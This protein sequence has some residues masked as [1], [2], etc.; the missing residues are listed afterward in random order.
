V[1][2]C[3]TDIPNIKT[4]CVP[5][6]KAKAGGADHKEIK[7]NPRVR[8]NGLDVPDQF[9]RVSGGREYVTGEQ[10]NKR[11]GLGTGKGEDFTWYRRYPESQ[12]KKEERKGF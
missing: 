2:D 1:L 5:N 7:R 12:E 10:G 9:P 8:E 3:R 6:T 11:R 4:H